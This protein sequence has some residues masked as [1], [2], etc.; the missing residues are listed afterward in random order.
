[1][2]VVLVDWTVCAKTFAGLILNSNANANV[3]WLSCALG[4]GN[5]IEQILVF[6]NVCDGE[7]QGVTS[8]DFD[9]TTCTLWTAD[10]GGYVQ[11]WPFAHILRSVHLVAVRGEMGNE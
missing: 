5:T 4:A 8:I 3:V 1:M 6:A 10:Q 7:K 2:R 9:P 11:K